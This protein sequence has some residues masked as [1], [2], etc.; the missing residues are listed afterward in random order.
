MKNN[1]KTR[2]NRLSAGVKSEDE[3][4]FIIDPDFYGNADKLA[5]LGYSSEPRVLKAG[6]W[7]GDIGWQT[8]ERH[9]P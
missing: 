8:T 6:Q 5:A 3:V 9:E 4:V 7:Y 1:L 2:I